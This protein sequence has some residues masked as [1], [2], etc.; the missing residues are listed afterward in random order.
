MK[1]VLILIL[2]SV[3]LMGAASAGDNPP[4]HN[5]GGDVTVGVKVGVT[6]TNDNTNLNVNENSNT[7]ILKNKSISISDGGDARAS[8]YQDQG[9]FQSQGNSQSIVVEDS[10]EQHYSGEYRVEQT[11]PAYSPPMTSMNPCL[12]GYSGG[13]GGTAGA[14]SLGGY[15][16]DE[17]CV[18][19]N[20]AQV[21][22]TLGHAS[23]AI[24]V[25]CA[26]D[27]VYAADQRLPQERRHCSPRKET[28]EDDK[29][30]IASN[31]GW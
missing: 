16:T 10:G 28:K 24:E 5:K 27:S 1:K 22:N 4:G 3:F 13:I 11:V 21:I 6:N 30:G 23:L 15:V 7:N 26:Q 8:S 31:F 25:M 17:D 9:Q 18:A 19:Q 14:I 20:N 12:I 2:A 29:D